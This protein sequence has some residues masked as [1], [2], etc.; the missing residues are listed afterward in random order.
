MIPRDGAP[1]T[2]AVALEQ[3]PESPMKFI[4]DSGRE[5]L[6]FP[7]KEGTTIVGRDQSCDIVLDHPK[8]SR[9]HLQCT[10]KAG[11]V[12]IKDLGSRNGTFVSDVQVSECKLMNGDTLRVGGEVQLI[13]DQGDV[14]DQATVLTGSPPAPGAPPPPP[15][16]DDRLKNVPSRPAAP[17]G[18][19][20]EDDEPTP[21]DE[22]M[23]PAQYAGQATSE[24]RVVERNGRWYAVDPT[25]GREI[26]IQ[27]V[28]YP[29][30]PP[31]GSLLQ[32]IA[33]LRPITK[34]AIIGLTLII[35]L[36]I[37]AGL[38]SKGKGGNKP[39]GPSGNTP[40]KAQYEQMIEDAIGKLEE[41]NVLGAEK[42][43]RRAQRDLPKMKA[44][45]MLLDVSKLWIDLK[46][47]DFR[48][49][50][51][52]AESL[53]EEIADAA[54][55]PQKARTFARKQLDW[56]YQ[57]NDNEG[58]LYTA[59]QYA[60]RKNWAKAFE[61][62]DRLSKDSI[63]YAEVK[64]LK[65]KIKLTIVNDALDAASKAC[66]E[67]DWD[68][69]LEQ[70]KVVLQYEPDYPNAKQK[71]EECK[72]NAVDKKKLEEAKAAKEQ[73]DWEQVA[74]LVDGINPKGPYASEAADL[75]KLVAT[76]SVCAAAKSLFDSGDAEGALKKLAASNTPEAQHLAGTIRYVLAALQKADEASAKKDFAA[77]VARWQDVVR[78][79]ENEDN[80]YRQEAERK[81]KGWDETVEKLAM[82][83]VDK[84]MKAFQD[85]KY[86]DA[87][88]AFEQAKKM[89]PKGEAGVAAIQEMVKMAERLY[90][91]AYAFRT[92]R[93]DEAKKLL[94]QVKD[95][96]RPGDDL[97][98]KVLLELSRLPQKAGN[99]GAG[100]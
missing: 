65:A 80:R 60:K 56:I 68:K 75:K 42:L 5:R 12:V 17:E 4:I 38:A 14:S 98:P 40:T 19:V 69:A 10:V 49:V 99:A 59:N 50:R 9:R 74:L 91:R 72:H 96:L 52:E 79:I 22:N 7:L 1:S 33:Q 44:A 94:L 30:K 57:E 21:E 54:Y 83:L 67:Q 62:F 97:Y 2:S 53:F 88:D 46:G 58:I 18:A 66:D 70:Y 24:A 16:V 13:F 25:T 6:E 86:K 76:K 41:N 92:S 45:K 78:V 27:P 15:T 37:V 71:V 43:L 100:E 64:D 26:E 28:G 95:M 23:L 3:K 61:Y 84:G 51:G 31:A 77:A 20:D 89:D 90:Y 48:A 11:Q 29:A 87:R 81:I 36:A 73:E 93:P 39:A 47:K 85:A 34:A 8:V 63:F 82:K 55:V 35:V 32:K